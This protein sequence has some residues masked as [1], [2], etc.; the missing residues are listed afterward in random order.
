MIWNPFKKKEAPASSD[1]K[2]SIT[3]KLEK[4]IDALPDAFKSKLKD[5]TIKERFMSIARR[6][7]ADG[8]NFKSIRQMKKWMKDHEAELRAEGNPEQHH[9]ETVVHEGP[10]IGRNDPCP[11]GSGKKYKKCCGAGK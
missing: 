9:I 11:C 6:M 7:E 8:V 4:E 1:G 2:S 5:P 3:D 10:R